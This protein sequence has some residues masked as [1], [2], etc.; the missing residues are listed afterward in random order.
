VKEN[1]MPFIAEMI[2]TVLGAPEDEKV[3]AAVRAKVN[4]TMEEFPLF[5]Y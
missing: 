1:M 3:I 5:A 4:E 2:E